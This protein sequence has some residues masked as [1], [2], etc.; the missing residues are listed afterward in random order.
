MCYSTNVYKLL[1]FLMNKV[2][3]WQHVSSF[4]S[5]AET[6]N[7]TLNTQIV[8]SSLMQWPQTT[9]RWRPATWKKPTG[10]GTLSGHLTWHWRAWQRCGVGQWEMWGW[11]ELADGSQALPSGWRTAGAPRRTRARPS[12]DWYFRN[13]PIPE[14]RRTNRNSW[15]NRIHAQNKMLTPLGSTRIKH[16]ISFF[17]FSG[18]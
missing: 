6:S 12:R 1:T 11:T 3:W 10:N 8:L 9:V 13:V 17:F 18:A 7:I 16:C 14:T 15:H 5:N 2:S 4:S